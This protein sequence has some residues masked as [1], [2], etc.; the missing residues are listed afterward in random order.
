MSEE[1][2]R[3]RPGVPV[4]GRLHAWRVAVRIARRDA[5]RYKARSLLV[6]AMIAVPIIGVSAA[7]VTI[8]S[9]Q[10]SAAEKA[11]RELGAADARLSDAQAG[12]QP[13]YQEPTGSSLPVREAEQRAKGVETVDQGAGDVVPVDAAKAMPPG[14]RWVT[15]QRAY[16]PVMT[17]YGLLDTEIRELKAGDPIARGITRLVR[18]R[19]PRTADET[20]ATTGFLKSSGL[21]VGSRAKVR[22][23]GRSYTIVGAY[24]LPSALGAE[25]LDVLPGAFIAP[26]KASR[27]ASKDESFDSGRTYLV[28][29]EGDFTWDMVKRANTL[30]VVVDSRAVRE[31]PPA[32]ADVPLYQALPEFGREGYGGGDARAEAVAAAVTIVSLSMLEICLLAGPA[33]A[34]GARRSR[35]QLGLVGAN[36]GDRRHI[37]AIV[38]SSGL[39]I[40]AAAAVV[41][42]LL[43]IAATELLRGQLESRV[44]ARFGGLKLRPLELAAIGGLAVLT[45]VLAAVVPAVAASRQ[46]VLASLTGRRGVRRA[47]RVLP[48]VGLFLLCLGVGVLLYTTARADNPYTAVLGAGLAEIGLA[49]LTSVLIGLFG[50][51]GRWL[52]LAPRLALRDAVRNRGRTAPAVAAVLAAVAGSVA[53]ATYSAS[54]S[55]ED[56]QSYQAQLPR[57]VVAVAAYDRD[58]QQDLGRVRAAVEKDYPVTGR[59]DVS[60]IYVGPASCAADGGEHCGSVESV[61]PEA[62][63][64]PS[65]RQDSVP[66]TEEQADA[67]VHDWRCN[68]PSSP[69]ALLGEGGVLV[70][71]PGVLHALGVR[72]GAAEQALARG[73]T[74]LFDRAYADHGMFKLKVIADQSDV[75]DDGSEPKGQ[76]KA[77]PMYL[78]AQARSYGVTAVVPQRAADEAGLA[79]APLGSYFTTAA[80]PSG[81]QRQALAADVA[82]IGTRAQVYVERGYVGKSGVILLAL[83]IFAGLITIGASGITTGLAQADA[84]PDLR[85]LAAIGAAGRLRRT[86]SGFQCAVVAA[87]GVLLGSVAGVLPVIAL[88]R[89]DQRHQWEEYRRMIMQGWADGGAPAHVPVAVPWTTLG[90]LVVAVPVGAGLLAALVTRSRPELGRRAEA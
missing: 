43:G 75:P 18:G 28:S 21:H 80:M 89:V 65:S 15:D 33:F 52:P 53:V 59:V 62:N 23:F 57:G 82:K 68:R 64:C 7:D 19:F 11:D 34:V 47:S 39:V 14:A 77:L 66:V 90:L 36:G 4:V 55:L 76:V 48:A 26:Y 58:A 70:G 24:E 27:D 73:R 1:N 87:M 56:R 46:S 31:H 5:L 69:A 17:K 49:M 35:R 83:T 63:T 79:T 72:D 67:L 13:V 78:A 54:Q 71:G 10:L 12:P 74:V 44:D 37:R 45:G 86:L 8:R 20:S 60:Q 81:K 2:G 38:I 9:S 50:R 84:E 29:V 22:G 88:R 16:A 61:K 42:T 40:G 85:T 6:L 41:G 25:Q 30:G 3:A 51:L 32:R